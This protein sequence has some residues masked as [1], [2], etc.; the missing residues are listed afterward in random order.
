MQTILETG[1][2]HT[3]V[4]DLN[5][6]PKF[7]SRFLLDNPQHPVASEANLKRS[8]IGCTLYC[9]LLCLYDAF[10]SGFVVLY[11]PLLPQEVKPRIS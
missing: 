3:M 7:W 5:D 9:D 8:S 6:I 2:L 10:H 4:S 11:V 1:H